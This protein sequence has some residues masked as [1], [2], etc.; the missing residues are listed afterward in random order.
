MAASVAH[1][2]SHRGDLLDPVLGG[3]VKKPS[4]RAPKKK[5]WTEF[6]NPTGAQDLMEDRP[7]PAD[8][9]PPFTEDALVN[10]V[11]KPKPFAGESGEVFVKAIPQV[12]FVF[13]KTLGL[14]AE[15][16]DTLESTKQTHG[17]RLPLA[18]ANTLEKLTNSLVRLSKEE[19]EI[20]ASA[21][22]RKYDTGQLLD[23]IIEDPEVTVELLHRIQ[24]RCPE[25]LR[26][27]GARALEEVAGGDL[28]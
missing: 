10:R 18:Q 25:L 5:A 1:F 14:I 27:F 24:E 2:G 4:A 11:S 3:V 22:E 19:R 15:M 16:L 20:D 13:G 28:D 6:F 12:D 23:L 26:P 21:R 7:H 17:G 8:G 9:V